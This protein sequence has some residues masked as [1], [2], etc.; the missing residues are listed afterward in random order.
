MK[1]LFVFFALLAGLFGL[2]SCGYKSPAMSH[3]EFMAAE[4]GD[5][6]IIEG[7]ISARQSWWNGA[8]LYLT[9]NNE[10]EGYFI[11][12]YQCTE[13]EYNNELVVGACLRVYGSKTIYDGEHEI[14]GENVDYEKSGVITNAPEFAEKALKVTTVNNEELNKHQNGLFTATLKVKGTYTFKDSTNQTDDIYFTLVDE[15]GNELSCCVEYYLTTAYDA[16]R[17]VILSEGFVEG[18]SVTVTGYLYW[19]QTAA[20]PH[21]TSIVVNK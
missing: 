3:E 1:K 15:A 4:N 9:T 20:N 5:D 12:G 21:I 7:Y 6:V 17:T 14:M 2:A 18:A 13:E 8:T 16:V 10:G 11:Y 19:W